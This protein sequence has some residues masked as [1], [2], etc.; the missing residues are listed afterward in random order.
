MPQIWSAGDGETDLG[1]HDDQC[2]DL[3]GAAFSQEAGRG[4]LDQMTAGQP[5]SF[6]GKDTGA[7]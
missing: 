4:T 7:S 3:N 5:T 1:L 2:F 6:F